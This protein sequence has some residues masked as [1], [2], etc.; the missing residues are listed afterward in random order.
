MDPMPLVDPQPSNSL[1]SKKTSFWPLIF[2]L[3]LFFIPWFSALGAYL[4]RNE[5]NISIQAG[6][7]LLKSHHS[8][9]N[10]KLYNH[11]NQ[12]LP[13]SSLIGKWQLLYI[14]YNYPHSP[15]AKLITALNNL[16]LALGKNK[17][18]LSIQTILPNA[19]SNWLKSDSIVV[20]DPMGFMILYYQSN[21]PHKVILKDLQKLMKLNH[22]S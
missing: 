19:N 5:L 7:E 16:R 9:R 2:L 6:G 15:D 10:L 3:I 4:Y 14:G 12:L 20:V 11:Q 18:K 8:I 22:V 1:S 13:I 21:T 17:Q